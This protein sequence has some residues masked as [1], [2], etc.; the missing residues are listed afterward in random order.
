MAQA[1]NIPIEAYQLVESYQLGLPLALHNTR[2]Q[3]LRRYIIP[4][5]VML[6]VG[7]FTFLVGLAFV[8]ID[9]YQL[10]V[11]NSQHPVN[12]Y[13]AITIEEQI[14]QIQNHLVEALLPLVLGFI[15]GMGALIQMRIVAHSL[16]AYI[17]VC[18]HGLLKV[19]PKKVDVTRWEEVTG[20]LKMPGRAEK[21]MLARKKRKSIIFANGLEDVE[22]LANLI[23]QYLNLKS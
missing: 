10:Q 7:I 6:C 22:G 21:Y 18:T 12:P 14:S 13:N 2:P 19:Q 9:V 8:L 15:Y 11:L 23:K 1:I 17:L 20:F 3:M 16:P 5:R 4:N